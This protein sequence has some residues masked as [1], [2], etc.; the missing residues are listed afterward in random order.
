MN[1][2][3]IVFSIVIFVLASIYL[4]NASWRVSV[5][6][7]D[8][9]FVAHRGVH[10]THTHEGINDQ[11]CTAELIYP[12]THDYIENTLPSIQAAFQAS[13]DIVEIDIHPTI[14]GDFAV[15]HDWSLECRTNG[16]GI[17]RQ[18]TM[19]Y[20]RTLDAGYGYTADNGQSYPLRGQ[21]TGLIP[22]LSDVLD[23]FPDGHH[24]HQERRSMGEEREQRLRTSC[25]ASPSCPA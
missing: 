24:R 11:S 10:Q 21:A 17:T 4:M 16:S 7:A 19:S 23:A 15:F 14:D 22:S 8:P 3:K 2:V 6:Q 9:Y 25:G 1:W 5:K 18:Q 20:L 13:A 12:P